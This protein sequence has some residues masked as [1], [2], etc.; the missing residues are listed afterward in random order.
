VAGIPADALAAAEQ[1]AR[2][3]DQAT[4]WRFTLHAP[5]YL[6]YLT[7]SEYRP[8]REL[9]WRAF[10]QRGFRGDANDTRQTVAKLV[11]PDLQARLVL[12][13]LRGQQVH[14]AIRGLGFH[15]VAHLTLIRPLH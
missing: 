14:R 3:G 1:A 10:A 13:A 12:R 7:Y 4:G 5:S 2:E 11:R 15:L 9:L 6:A 8:G